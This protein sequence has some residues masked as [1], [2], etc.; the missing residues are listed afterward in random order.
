MPQTPIEDQIAKQANDFEDQMVRAIVADRGPAPGTR[1]LSLND[2]LNLWH[3]EVPIEFSH[4][5]QAGPQG[6]LALLQAVE[7]PNP[8]RVVELLGSPETLPDAEMVARFP[9]RE[10]LMQAGREEDDYAGKVAYAERMAQHSAKRQEPPPPPM[11]P[12][13]SP[14]PPAA[15]SPAPMP[16]GVTPMPT[17][18]G[19]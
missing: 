15:V 5:L 6:A 16:P 11:A 13:T 3:L 2:E 7:H 12:S 10:K 19:Y 1:K 4:L 8:E 14:V 17:A 9:Y 18:G